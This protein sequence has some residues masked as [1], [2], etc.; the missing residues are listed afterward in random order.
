M[1][2]AEAPIQTTVKLTVD[3][4]DVEIR[5]GAS[6]LDAINA[7]GVFVPQLC[8]DPDQKPRGACRTCLVQIEGVRGFPAS[9]TTPA[10]AGM[11]VHV[12]DAAPA[13]IRKG[14][15]ELTMGMHPD[16]CQTNRP[17]T[18]NDVVDAARAHG[19][20]QPRFAPLPDP[21]VDDSNPFF[22]VDMQQCI[23]CARCVTACD[24]V[25]HIGAIALLNRG[26]TM[27]IG[28]YEDL[29]MRES[30]CTSCGSCF[31][32]CPTGAIYPKKVRPEPVKRVE[33][34]CPYC[35]VGCGIKADVTPDNRIMRVDDQPINDSSQGMLCV[36]GR[37]GFEFVNHPDRLTTP[38]IK[39]HG[40]FEEATWDEALDLVADKFVEHRGAFGAL[41]SA[42]AT[43][44][45]GYIIQK[46]ARSVMDTNNIDHC[47]RLCHSPSVHAML[48]SLGSGATSNSY[49]DYENAGC[50]MVVGSDSSSNHPV[51]TVRFRRAV[52]RGAKLI[53]VNPKW[54]ELNYY[55]DIW[56]QQLP[57]TDVALFNGMAYVL[58]DE[59]LADM[60]FI[61]S[62]T[63]GFEEWA[64]AVRECSPKV[65]SSITSVPEELIVQAARTFA[66]P[67]FNGSCMIWGMGVS[68]HSNGTANAHSVINLALAAGMA[69]KPANGISPLR[70]QNNVQ[71]AGDAGCVPDNLPGYQ[72]LTDANRS[73]FREAWGTMTDRPAGLTVT[74][75]VQAADKG[76]MKAMYVVGENPFLDEANLSHAKHAMQKLDFLVVQDIFMQETAQAADVVLPATTFAEKE[77]TFT[78]SE[79]RVQRVRPLIPPVGSSRPDWAITC[80]IARRVCKRLGLDERQ[81]DFA[82]PAEIFDEMAS[83]TPIVAGLSHDRLDREGG[84]QWP[85]PTP[86]HPGT[87]NLYTDNFPL[88]GGKAVLTPVRQGP[89][90]AELPDDDYP[91]ILN[92][93]RVLYHWH[94]GTMTSRVE[95]LMELV[96][97]VELT[98]NPVDAETF[99]VR[100]RGQV[101]ATTRRGSIVCRARVSEEVRRG[102]VFMPFVSLEGTAANFLTNDVYDPN[103][104]PEY[105]VCAVKIE[106]A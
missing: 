35:G 45:D 97:V 38:L 60:A 13:R 43:N 71:G 61:N 86:D 46:F 58:L 55:A 2:I 80:D 6:V 81:F 75:M 4:R 44:E 83:I 70:G 27:K 53:V 100:P 18:H 103:G 36:K 85:C 29:P 31:A 32:A 7:S 104:M 39:R 25:Q 12:D 64:A 106:A 91:L 68:Q 30:I 11:V 49:W 67:P 102:E 79:R 51:V 20:E 47:T 62:R 89:A 90:A 23:L 1:A 48:K 5:Q 57:G 77:G 26:S 15:L 42:K 56:L 73:K 22:V 19:I 93:G 66:R 105:K 33:T 28:T 92:T 59:G 21:T 52:K 40:V 99:G 69:G 84:I 9:C 96:P 95:G 87:P 34:T 94:G 37:F 63:E 74:G 16:W 82:S 50:L 101:R 24:E 14:V 76:E 72:A 88:P 41:A 98:V 65:A 54:T 3:G 17:N 10:A 78:N 8:K